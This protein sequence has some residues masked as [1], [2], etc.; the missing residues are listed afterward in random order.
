MPVNSIQSDRIVAIQLPLKDSVSLSI[1][2]VYLPSTDHPASEYSDY[3]ID[4]ES[5]ISSLQACGPTLIAGDFNAHL[6][7]LGCK[8]NNDSPNE[9]GHMLFDV[10]DR[11][12]LYVPSQS[13]L[14]KG[15]RYTY[16]QG[17]HRTTVDYC[18]LDSGCAHLTDDC[19]TLMPAALNLS[20]HL[21]I[22]ITLNVN[23]IQGSCHDAML[24]L[25]WQLAEKR[26]NVCDYAMAVSSFLSGVMARP[27]P[28]D[29]ESLEREISEVCCFLH[30]TALQLIPAKGRKKRKFFYHDDAL[31]Q[32]CKNSKAVWRRWANE[33]RPRSGQTYESL[34]SAK[35]EVKHQLR[36]CKGKED[37]K[38]IQSRDVMF[39]TQNP[40]RFKLPR[41]HQPTC[42]KLCV[43]GITHTDSTSLLQCWHDH[44]SAL[45]RSSSLNKD[46]VNIVD[47]NLLYESSKSNEDFVLD[48]EMS[49]EEVEFAVKSLKNGKSCGPDNVS[50]EHLKNGGPGVAVWMKRIFNTITTLEVIPPVFNHS[51][52][53]PVFKGKGR[54]PT[55]PESYRGISLTSV[56][57]KCLEKVLL[58]RLLPVLKE[59]GFPHPSQTA[60]LKDRSCID[61]VFV[62]NEVLTK[63]LTSGDSP[64]LC[65]YDLEKAFDS[66]EYDVLLH[67]LYAAGINGKAWRLI[68]S[69]YTNPTSAVRFS[70]SVSTPF[71][72]TR[73]VKQGAVLSPILFNLVM[74]RVLSEMSNETTSLYVSN[75]NVGCSAHADDIRSCTIGTVNVERGAKTLQSV[76]SENSLRLNML[77]TEIVHL[78]R[79]P[80]RSESINIMDTH[81]DTKTEAKCLGVWWCQDLSSCKSVEENIMKSRRA[82][83]ALGAIDVFQGTCNP[84]T[85]LSLFNTFVLPILS[86]GCEVWSLNDP[87]LRKLDSFQGEVGKKILRLPKFYNNL[88]VRLGLKWPSFKVIIL[89]RKLCY[90]AKLLSQEATNTHTRLFHSLAADN[91]LNIA[92]VRQ[93]KELEMAYGTNYWRACMDCP[94]DAV[95]IVQEARTALLQ[96]DWNTT[97][98]SA[99]SH[100]SLSYISGDEVVDEWYGVWDEALNHGTKGTKVAQNIFRSL[101]RPLFGDKQCSLCC[102]TIT[103]PTYVDHVATAHGLP[104]VH[105]L[106]SVHAQKPTLFTS[107]ICDSCSNF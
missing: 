69:W 38:R 4:L 20:D 64:Y 106:D 95:H 76:T 49:L 9:A 51:I 43:D 58:S 27:I 16:A 83:F 66:I 18:L 32:K 42:N 65:L 50:A 45:G 67:H 102:H 80:I 24:R 19:T 5:T 87:L 70:G 47:S 26:G 22:V 61:G 33:G 85:A 82:F 84:L 37:R 48:Y 28:S 100:P 36:L 71:V 59:H 62:T 107:P 96:A 11:C 12:D 46:S 7:H 101:C 74:D 1:I 68:R 63:L 73:G 41:K 88:S 17:P 54:D 77:K 103:E 15:E 8:R 31:Q 98:N 92:L 91:A 53:V 97:V 56:I 78:S 57:G 81:V 10:I 105:I 44:F 35:C 60:Y 75:V 14:A 40:N 90:L 99:R 39:K 34:K 25:N 79:H 6:G 29:S 55:N 23:T 93:C 30:D 52:I 72:I 86:Y 21:P 89:I 3:L 13:A 104:L 94:E 2:G